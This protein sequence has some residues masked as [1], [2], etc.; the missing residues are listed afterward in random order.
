MSTLALLNLSYIPTRE[1]NP[2]ALWHPMN[3]MNNTFL[4][5]QWA[6]HVPSLEECRK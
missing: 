5:M 6:S 2:N 3:D 4:S 1:L